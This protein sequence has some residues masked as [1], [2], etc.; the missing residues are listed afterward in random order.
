MDHNYCLWSFTASEASVCVLYKHKL[1]PHILLISTISFL[2]FLPGG[3]SL[4]EVMSLGVLLLRTGP[5]SEAQVSPV[6]Q[7]RAPNRDKHIHEAEYCFTKSTGI[8]PG[9]ASIIYSRANSVGTPPLQKTCNQFLWPPAEIREVNICHNF[10]GGFRK[11]G[12]DNTGMMC[13]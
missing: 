3:T 12:L 4:H 5:T 10:S 11:V 13:L 7:A 8:S 9:P 2:C 1:I 6:L